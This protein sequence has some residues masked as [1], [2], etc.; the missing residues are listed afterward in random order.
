MR[1]C[2]FGTYDF[3]YSR[4]RILIE[5][6]KRNGVEVVECHVPLWQGTSDKVAAA[7]GGW[8]R[9]GLALRA[10]RAYATLLRQF[11]TVGPCDA[12]VLGYMGQIDA[13][14]ARLVANRRQIPLVLDV[15]MSIS[16][17]TRERRL[18]TPGDPLDRLV[19]WVERTACRLADMVWL[20]TR[21]YVDYFLERYQ[22]S[23]SAFRLIP[24][25]ADDRYFYPV[26]DGAADHGP[27]L[28]RSGEHP[29]TVSYVGKYVPLHGIP[30]VIQAAALLRD[31][32]VRFELIG[33]GESKPAMVALAQELGADNVTFEG[34]VEKTQLARRLAPS[35]VC[36]GVFGRERQGMMT[37]ANK[38][39]EGLAMRKPV[40]TGR[41]PA[42][43]AAFESGRH[44]LLVPLEDP[45][46]LADA[47]RQVRDD[48]ALRQRLAE[49]GYR[50]YQAHYTPTA[51]G[52]LAVTYLHE[53]VHP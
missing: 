3:N 42:V 19:S 33:E 24:T 20:D 5:G 39:Y 2:Y 34:W 36:L 44:L 28:D 23:P 43:E 48:P 21:F 50:E 14:V 27:A 46:A 22:L 26:S 11:R 17:I 49:E 18:V 9:P 32:G 12:V 37:V 10:M 45:E 31:E 30:T 8:R 52:A 6:L 1:V 38:V 53:L 40:I 16:L 47:I 51:L 13:F 4:N 41:T 15:F 29:F 7:R 25:G 35:D